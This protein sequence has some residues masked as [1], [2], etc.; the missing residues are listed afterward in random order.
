[1]TYPNENSPKWCQDHIDKTNICDGS[2]KDCLE[3]GKTLCDKSSTCFGIMYHPSWS[4]W[5]KGLKVCIS[6][7][8]K[9][10]GDWQVFMKSDGKGENIQ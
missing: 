10:K 7:Q 9:A 8:M 2:K 3:K 5:Y 1:M 4:S 6:S